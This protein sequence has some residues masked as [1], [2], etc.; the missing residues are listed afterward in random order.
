M[1]KSAVA[2]VALLAL[3]FAVQAEDKKEEKGKVDKAKLVG[4]WTF[5]K[6]D[7]EKAPPEG[8]TITFEFT[9]DGKLNVAFKVMDSE[10]KVGGTY[11][12]DGDKLEFALKMGNKENKETMTIKELTDKKLV[13]VSKKGDKTETTEFKK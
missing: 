13:W 9:K 1:R 6:T 7:S 5:V 3:A 8:A 10:F 12:V 2:V 4:T 11:K